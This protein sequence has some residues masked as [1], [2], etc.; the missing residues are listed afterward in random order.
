MLGLIFMGREVSARGLLK[1][2]RF[3]E[4]SSKVGA[5]WAELSSETGTT[6]AGLSWA[7]FFYGPSCPGPTCFWTELSVLLTNQM[8][9]KLL[10]YHCII[11]YVM[12]VFACL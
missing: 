4:R 8:M 5:I 10:S 9:I 6:W 2:G 12:F 1:L 3:G 7:D 11:Y